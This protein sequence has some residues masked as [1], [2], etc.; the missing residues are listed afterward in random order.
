MSVEKRD[1]PRFSVDSCS[2]RIPVPNAAP[3]LQV[4]ALSTTRQR[5]G[6]PKFRDDPTSSSANHLAESAS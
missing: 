1:T 3:A 5:L 6:V 4:L 2:S